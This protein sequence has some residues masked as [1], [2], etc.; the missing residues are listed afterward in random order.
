MATAVPRAGENILFRLKD[1][2]F[3]Q[4]IRPEMAAHHHDV[5]PGNPGRVGDTASLISSKHLHS[6]GKKKFGPVFSKFRQTTASPSRTKRDNPMLT[7]AEV[8]HH[9]ALAEYRLGCSPQ[10]GTLDAIE[11]LSQPWLRSQIQRS[12]AFS[13]GDRVMAGGTGA[14]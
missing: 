9:F 6:V 4:A 2:A 10:S 11:G 8:A 5:R 3:P 12:Q 14:V 13:A 7:T 1:Q